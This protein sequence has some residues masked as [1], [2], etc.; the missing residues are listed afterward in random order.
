MKCPICNT[1]HGTTVHKRL[2]Q[3]PKWAP[4]LGRH[5]HNHGAHGLNAQSN[6]VITRPRKTCTMSHA[7]EFLVLSMTNCPRDMDPTSGS[8]WHITNT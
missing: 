5:G 4:S 2:I 6:G 3:C 8:M 7:K 1:R